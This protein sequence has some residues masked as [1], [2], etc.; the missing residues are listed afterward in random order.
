MVRYCMLRAQEIPSMSSDITT[1]PNEAE[2]IEPSRR[3]INSAYKGFR[4]GQSGNPG[5][6]SRIYHRSKKI[7]EAHSEELAA[8]LI[9]LALNA[10]D[11]RVSAMC[12][13]TGLGIAGLRPRDYDPAT[14]KGDRA[15]IDVSRLSD[16]QREQL[17]GL[18]SVMA[19]KDQSFE[20]EIIPPDAKDA[21]SS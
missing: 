8:R 15:A 5:G 19:E 6:F 12:T 3:A 11:E 9:Y 4:K 14:D 10:E 17:R 21:A 1:L 7:F 2:L 18:L 20:A 16:E 13:V